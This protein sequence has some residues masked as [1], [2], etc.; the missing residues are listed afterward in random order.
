MTTP[1]ALGGLC[2]AS[3]AGGMFASALRA[4][5]MF[6][7][8]SRAGGMFAF[9]SRAGGMFAFAS[10]AGGAMTIALAMLAASPGAGMAQEMSASEIM[11]R[12]QMQRGAADQI[13]ATA[14]AAA[15]GVAAVT[16]RAAAAPAAA[17]G[18]DQRIDL[19]ILFAR[20]SD[21]LAP[22][23]E[24]QLSQLCLAMRSDL[25]SGARYQIIG[26]TDATGDGRE[27]LI[28]SQSRAEAVTRWLS[29]PECGLNPY[30][31]TP[32]G[33]GETRLKLPDAPDDAANRRVEILLRG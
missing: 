32:V 5:G 22:K 3:R 28:L 24:A 25:E 29:G 16:P 7:F 18:E 23:A 30:R 20:G 1:R 27:N 9:A 11:R 31:L 12:L 26:H 19:E 17:R 15:R 6:A 2:A 33:L 14:T 10:R 21:H 13:P 8:A 4:G